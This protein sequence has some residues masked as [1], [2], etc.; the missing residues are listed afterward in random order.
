MRTKLKTMPFLLMIRHSA[1]RALAAAIVIKNREPQ[2]C[3]DIA[4]DILPEYYKS[5]IKRRPKKRG[6]L[7]NRL[8]KL[9]LD[10]IDKDLPPLITCY[11][12]T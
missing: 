1:P 8:P 10:G 6:M 4:W 3:A 12:A 9:E 11:L 7:K 2:V 5:L